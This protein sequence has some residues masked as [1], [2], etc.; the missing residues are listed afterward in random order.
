MGVINTFAGLYPYLKGSGY[1]SLQE[2][3]DAIDSLNQKP[4]FPGHLYA[5]SVIGD[6][7]S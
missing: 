3:L 7:A 1:R 5:V 4:M 2:W 6:L